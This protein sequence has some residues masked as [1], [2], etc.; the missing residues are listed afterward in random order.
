MDSVTQLALGGAVA[1]AAMGSKIGRKAALYGAVL[2]TLP[3]LDVLVPYAGDVENFVFHRSFSHSLFVQALVSP[4][5]AWLLIKLHPDT[6]ALKFR[7]LITVY[8]CLSTHALLDAFTVYGTQLLWPLTDY[9]FGI[10][11][12]FIIDP[13]YTL[14]IIFGLIVAMF[15]KQKTTFAIKANN[16]GLVISCLYLAWGVGAKI[17]VDSLVHKSLIANGIDINNLIIESTPAPLTTFV[18]RTVAVDERNHYEIYSSIFDSADEVSI[19]AYPNDVALP[20][21]ISSSWHMQRL[22]AFTK[23]LNY[24]W[25]R[26]GNVYFSDLR[27]GVECS[28]VF[29][30]EVGNVIDGKIREGSYQQL[31]VQPDLS[32]L[33]LL[34][35]RI[36]DSSVKLSPVSCIN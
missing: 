17:Y 3:D 18:W 27:M 21:A 14:P 20:K 10:S 13:L 12:V 16:I 11:S 25:R 1:Y 9:P 31:E 28:Y 32:K 24:I 8:L 15:A 5:L 4:L 19:T 29:T 6:K 2:G 34:F 7:W 26:D 23:G 30:F 36:T 33:S 35:D 22:S